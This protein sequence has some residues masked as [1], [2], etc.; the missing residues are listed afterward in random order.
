MC[1][2]LLS[3]WCKKQRGPDFG[4]IVS[5]NNRVHTPYPFL[6]R[7]T[8]FH[9][10]TICVLHNKSSPKPQSNKGKGHH[11]PAEV[12]PIKSPPPHGTIC[13]VLVNVFD[14]HPSP[15]DDCIW[16]SLQKNNIMI[17]L[18]RYYSKHVDSSPHTARHHD[19]STH[20][21]QITL[22]WTP[23]FTVTIFSR[24]A[25][26]RGLWP[27]RSRGFVITHDDAQHSVGLLWTSDQL[28]AE[29]STW[30]NTTHTTDNIHVPGGIRAHDRS[31]RADVVPRFR[32][33]GYW[34]RLYCTPYG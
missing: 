34:D 7:I 31:R 29:T 32:P 5:W 23:L 14:I 3:T 24:S 28:V 33:R 18:C 16:Q 17:C 26:Q 22:Y 13:R 8:V 21:P 30:Q 9:P 19:R 15:A 4:K 20:V 12:F 11:G 6:P 2:G 10:L 27:P 25:A 1:N